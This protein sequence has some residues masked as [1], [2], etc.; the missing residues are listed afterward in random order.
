[1]SH[2]RIVSLVPSLTE[3]VIDL[4]LKDRLVGRTRFCIHP[5]GLVEDIPIIGGTKNLNHKKIGQLQPD[6]II[7]NLEENR[8]KDVELLH[9]NYN[10][11]LT[12][13]NTIEDALGVIKELGNDFDAE[14]RALEIVKEITSLLSIP[15]QTKPKTVAYFIWKDPWMVAAKKTY[16]D[17]VL[18]H[19]NLQNIFS[20]KT[21]Y[22][23]ISLDELTQRSPELVLLSSEPY[24]FKEKHMQEIKK[25]CPDAEIQLI[26]GEWF[27]W[28]G[29]GMIN[30]CKELNTWR[31]TVDNTG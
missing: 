30:A 31:T 23:E 9:N 12:N 24:P 18:Q 19:Y 28:Y 13:I 17:S 1:M 21:R 20:D 22:P 11:N 6:Y 14:K 15:L 27:S 4:G 29:S 7:A 10:V 16:I 25:V 5:K 26:N 2:Q 3:L 8:K